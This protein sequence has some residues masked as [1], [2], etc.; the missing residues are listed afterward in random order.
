M[1]QVV[2]DKDLTWSKNILTPNLLKCHKNLE[3]YVTEL[4]KTEVIK[5]SV[6]KSWFEKK[7]Y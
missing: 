1:A 5:L 7:L 6:N 3:V 4:E 2:K